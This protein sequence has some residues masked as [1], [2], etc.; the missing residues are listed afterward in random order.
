MGTL[1][2]Y[3][4]SYVTFHIVYCCNRTWLF[5]LKFVL[6][7]KQLVKFNFST[8]GEV[9]ICVEKERFVDYGFHTSKHVITEKWDNI[10]VIDS[11][12]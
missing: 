10:L 1:Q 12:G 7:G 5:T 6:T 3:D 9:S 11:V 8:F 4:V 2:I